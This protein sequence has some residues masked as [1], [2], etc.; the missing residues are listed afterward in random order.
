MWFSVSRVCSTNWTVSPS[1]RWKVGLW[2][3][4]VSPITI[5]LSWRRDRVGFNRHLA[6]SEDYC[7][8]GSCVGLAWDD[9]FG[10]WASCHC[11]NVRKRPT[12]EKTKPR[13]S[14]VSA[15]GWLYEAA[16]LS[17]TESPLMGRRLGCGCACHF[18]GYCCC[19]RLTLSGNRFL[20]FT[21]NVFALRF[22]LDFLPKSRLR[23][24]GR[25]GG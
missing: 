15:K 7:G 5:C 4:E 2:K 22:Q 20:G 3:K 24:K 18:L 1:N 10:V 13:E 8:Q 11:R 9:I 17:L 16:F 12:S 25:W 19:F 14:W 6:N 21:V 23:K